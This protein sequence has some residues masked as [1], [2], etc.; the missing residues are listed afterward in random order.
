MNIELPLIEKPMQGPKSA[1]SER[2][3]FNL[4]HASFKPEAYK[5]LAQVRNGTGHSKITR[6]ADAIVVS[7]WPSQ[8]LWVGGYEI[9]CSRSDWLNEVKAPEK[10]NEIARHLHFWSVITA[11]ESFIRPGELPAAWGHLVPDK[12]GE[13]LR[14]VK[15]PT[16]NKDAV[17][18]WGFVIALL[19]NASDGMVPESMVTKEV[20]RRV[21]GLEERLAERLKYRAEQG[22]K[23]AE[24][25]LSGLKE[26]ILKFESR[27][28]LRISDFTGYS[29][30]AD[31]SK[32]IRYLMDGGAAARERQELER[33]AERALEIAASINRVMNFTGAEPDFSI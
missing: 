3:L 24:R 33:M 22:Q 26:E 1:H 9:K 8:G 15:E 2:S 13:K 5:V 17:P 16:M 18:E 29:F 32:V 28:G 19:R 6:T 4:L 14:T 31:A 12:K 21:E 23:E 30:G 25:N 27:T 10:S 11:E 20:N 7:L